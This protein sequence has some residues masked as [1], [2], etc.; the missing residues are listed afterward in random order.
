M[1]LESRSD[2]YSVDRWRSQGGSETLLSYGAGQSLDNIPAAHWDFLKSCRSSFETDS[3]LFAHANYCWYSDLGQQPAS[4]LRWTSIDE[5]T[6]RPHIS[7]KTVI[8]GHTPGSIRDR[9]FYRCIDT[10]CG[11]GGCLT[12]MDVHTGHFWQVH[13]NGELKKQFGQKGRLPS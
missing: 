2:K 8:L 10:G 6:P 1:M 3:F 4:L 13:E 5:E 9:G 11:F 12:A 7:G